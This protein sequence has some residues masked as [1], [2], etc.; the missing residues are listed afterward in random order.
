MSSPFRVGIP[1]RR[2]LQYAGRHGALVVILGLIAG[3]AFPALAEAAR[4]L[5]A[6][7]VLIFTFGSFLKLDSGAAAEEWA[8]APLSLLVAAWSAIGVPVATAL[9]LSRVRLDPG[10]AQGVLLWAAVP[11]SAASVAF[12]AILG[13]S[14]SLA[15][16]ATVLGTAAAPFLMPALI[17]ISGSGVALAADPMQ[18]CL[19]LLALLGGAAL[20]A[21][22]ARR[23]AGRFIDAN[24][25][26]MTGIAVL[27]LVLAGLGS[28]RGIQAAF[29]AEPLRVLALLLLAYL[30]LLTAQISGTL[31]FWPALG[32]KG[33][34]TAGLASGTRTITLAWVVLGP[35]VAHL[36][37][38]FLAMAMVAKYTT[39]A[40]TRGFVMR[41]HAE[42]KPK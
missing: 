31:L 18:M 33:A 25:D 13:L 14:P 12:A 1:M 38:L 27:A 16:V 15:L 36:A 22:V 2:I 30:L 23:L 21:L 24:P 29:F 37:D 32:A 34:L 40:L 35:D 3:F 41:L 8:R 7:A 17:A 10:L 26:G 6:L 11:T 42:S 20:L 39:P 9:V 28:M 19:R 5:L 4:P